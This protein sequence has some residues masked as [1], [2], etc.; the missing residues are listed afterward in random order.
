[1][2]LQMLE[3]KLRDKV[4]GSLFGSSIEEDSHIYLGTGW[5]RGLLPVCWRKKQPPQRDGASYA[6]N[7][8]ARRPPAA[9]RNDRTLGEGVGRP[10]RG[11]SPAGRGK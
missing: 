2:F 3:V 10:S 6:K 9:R 4:A 1:M 8:Q 11:I 5:T 7:D